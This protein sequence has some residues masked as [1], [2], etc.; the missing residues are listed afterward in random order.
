MNLMEV[1]D[2]KADIDLDKLNDKKTGKII[3]LTT[4]FLLTVKEA[5]GNITY[6]ARAVKNCSE[7]DKRITIE[8]YEIERRYWSALGIE[9]KVITDRELN[10]KKQLCKNIQWVRETQVASD[11]NI[12]NVDEL[13]ERL[14]YYLKN[15]KKIITKEVSHLGIIL[16]LL[17][18]LILNNLYLPIDLLHLFIN[19]LSFINNELLTTSYPIQSTSVSK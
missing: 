15:S 4:N 6:K 5:N 12:Q 10:S 2:D 14:F 13:L 17:S 1:I 11:N 16:A 7:L 19:T 9:W 8:K 18:I 3:T